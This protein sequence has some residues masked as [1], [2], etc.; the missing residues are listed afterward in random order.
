MT[1]E[2]ERLR[3]RIRERI[4]EIRER[5]GLGAGTGVLGARGQVKVG[6]GE[7]IKM[8]T[9]KLDEITRKALELRPNI[10]GQITA[11]KPGERVKTIVEETLGKPG[12]ARTQV[13]IGGGDREK[14]PF[15][16]KLAVEV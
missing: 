3:G 14:K 7:L 11:I 4:R 16:R 9:T 8:A 1:A 5:I 2:I 13:E 6:G 10:I 15:S 12:G